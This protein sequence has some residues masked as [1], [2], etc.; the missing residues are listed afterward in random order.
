MNILTRS[1]WT[2]CQHAFH[3]IKTK[4]QHQPLLQ[5]WWYLQK[6]RAI[7]L[8]PFFLGS[9]YTAECVFGIHL[10]VIKCH[11]CVVRLHVETPPPSAAFAACC[12]KQVRKICKLS[13]D[14][15]MERK[16]KP[17]VLCH[18]CGTTWLPTSPGSVS[19]RERCRLSSTHGGE[20]RRRETEREP[21]KLTQT[22]CF[23][24][25]RNET[26]PHS[27]ACWWVAHLLSYHGNSRPRRDWF[28]LN[29]GGHCLIEWLSGCKT[30]DDI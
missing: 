4:S 15:P 7:C 9:D 29:P 26:T 30:N 14:Q 2:C 5:T 22:W 19:E 17:C 20:A 16:K 18:T 24:W 23:L 27:L 1:L 3:L 11:H 25:K 13:T 10:K 6:A 8:E 21:D 12:G 28:R